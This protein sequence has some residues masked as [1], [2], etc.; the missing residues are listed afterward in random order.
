[1]ILAISDVVDVSIRLDIPI[2]EFS[3]ISEHLQFKLESKQILRLLLVLRTQVVL[4]M[5][6]ITFAAVICDADDPCSVNTA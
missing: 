2:W 3:A 5:I 4:E 1:M 6:S